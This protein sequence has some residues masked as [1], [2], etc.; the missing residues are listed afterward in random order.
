MRTPLDA[1]A[2]I[3]TVLETSAPGVGD[4]IDTVGGVVLPLKTVT[5]TTFEVVW[6]P[7]VSKAMAVRMCELLLVVV[8]SQDAK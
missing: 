1:L 2:E 5:E 8:V 7:A 3:D 6:L 4:P